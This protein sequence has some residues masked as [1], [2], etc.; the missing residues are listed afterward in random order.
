MKIIKNKIRKIALSALALIIMSAV[1]LPAGSVYAQGNPCNNNKPT[2]AGLN[3]CLKSNPI[4]KDVQTLINVLSVIAGLV[5]VGS[6]IVG[7]LQYIMAGDNS[8]AV[9]AAKDRIQ[10]ALLAF[11][12]FLFIF[13]FLNWLLPGGLLFD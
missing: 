3:S 9:S 13:A 2:E 4:I 7:G 12:A 1:V 8:N 5:I 11:L 6:V 10:N